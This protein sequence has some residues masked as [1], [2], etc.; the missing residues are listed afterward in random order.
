MTIPATGSPEAPKK[1]HG[2]AGRNL[3]VA[4]GS[5]LVLVGTVVASLA[6]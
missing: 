2:R 3:P 1:D 6:F 5:A 4:V